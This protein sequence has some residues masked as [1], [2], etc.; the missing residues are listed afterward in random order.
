M[1]LDFGCLSGRE[2]RQPDRMQRQQSKPPG[3][4]DI[5]GGA[6]N[7]WGVPGPPKSVPQLGRP[8]AGP[9]EAARAAKERQF[10]RQDLAALDMQ[11]EALGKD[12]SAIKNRPGNRG[13]ILKVRRASH[14]PWRCDPPVCL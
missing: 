13:R 5:G 1:G 3:P 12:W 2:Q 14:R 9:E 10:L 4:A 11:L 7:P 6:A 8:A